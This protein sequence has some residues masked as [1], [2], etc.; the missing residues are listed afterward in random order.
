MG[1]RIRLPGAAAVL[2]I[3]VS[4]LALAS[5]KGNEP[6]SSPGV[7]TGPRPAATTTSPPASSTAAFEKPRKAD[8]PISLVLITNNSSSFWDAMEKG[9]DVGK[10][11][12]GCDAKRVTPPG[13][14]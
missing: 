6:A 2:L 11:A 14:S 1:L 13:S 8:G 7:S 4:C 9:M 3:G 12:V 5:C 10:Q